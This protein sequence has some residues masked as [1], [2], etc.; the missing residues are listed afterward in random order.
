MLCNKFNVRR[1]I[2]AV[3]EIRKLSVKQK[4]FLANL[5]KLVRKPLLLIVILSYFGAAGPLYC[6]RNHA[7]NFIGTKH[8]TGGET[9]I[10]IVNI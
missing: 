7:D 1:K 10:Y 4:G 6:F 9:Y 3:F 2:P 5:L 8:H